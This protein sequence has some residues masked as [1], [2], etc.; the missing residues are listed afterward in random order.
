MN[1]L[2]IKEIESVIDNLP[3]EKTSGPDGIT[4]EFS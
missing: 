3:R 2:C 1:M 4:G